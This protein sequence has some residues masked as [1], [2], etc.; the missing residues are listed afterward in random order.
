LSLRIPDVSQECGNP[1]KVLVNFPSKDQYK[2][3][4]ITSPSLARKDKI[5][6]HAVPQIRD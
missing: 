5:I 6:N 2:K 4:K 1:I 3:K